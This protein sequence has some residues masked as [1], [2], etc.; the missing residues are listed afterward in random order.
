MKDVCLNNNHF[1]HRIQYENEINQ[2]NSVNRIGDKNMKKV[3]RDLNT[4]DLRNSIEFQFDEIDSDEFDGV[5]ENMYEIVATLNGEEVGFMNFSVTYGKEDESLNDMLIKLVEVNNNMQ[6]LGIGQLLYKEFGQIYARDFSGIPI[7][8]YF[9]NPVAEYAFRKAVSLG[10]IPDSALD[11]SRIKRDYSE[12]EE[13][14]WT[15]L[16][17]KLPESYRG[18]AAKD[19][20]RKVIS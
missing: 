17:Q 19:L 15:D 20:R 10:W 16:R 12:Q 1:I 14:L 4:I 6:G 8:R 9:V 3:A 18:V 2:K 13:Q 5:I 7:S 11:E